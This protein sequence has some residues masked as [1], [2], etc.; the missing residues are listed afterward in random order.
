MRFN[1]ITGR[2]LLFRRRAGSATLEASIVLMIFFLLA[3]GTVEFGYYLFVKHSLQGAAREG[4]RAAILPNQGDA[5]ARTEVIRYL[6]LAGLNTS[7]SALDSKW[8][9]T[10]SPSADTAASGTAI[11]VTIQGAW[12]TI[13][14]N[15]RPMRLLKDPAGGQRMVSGTCVMRK[16]G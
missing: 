11:T 14:A 8:T 7:N 4:C 1:R 15:M 12:A 6:T 16:E 9:V 2:S 3:F 10:I 13:G 5:A